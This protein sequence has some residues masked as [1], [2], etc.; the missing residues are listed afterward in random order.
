MVQQLCGE[1]TYQLGDHIRKWRNLR[2]IKQSDMANRLGIKNSA[3]SNIENNKAG[4]S[5]SRLEEIAAILQI[6]VQWLF[7][8]PVDLIQLPSPY[9][10]I[11]AFKF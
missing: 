4:I 6:E 5:R 7:I 9:T 10:G 3:M 11:S 1:Q 2:N 8:D